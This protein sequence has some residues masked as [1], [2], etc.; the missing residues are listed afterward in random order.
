MGK[1][2]LEIIGPLYIIVFSWLLY[3]IDLLHSSRLPIAGQL[4]LQVNAVLLTGKLNLLIKGSLNQNIINYSFICVLCLREE[5]FASPLRWVP[6]T[7]YL[8]YILNASRKKIKNEDDAFPSKA[9]DFKL[10]AER[11]VYIYIFSPDET[12]TS[13][14]T[15]LSPMM[16]S[17]NMMDKIRRSIL[18]VQPFQGKTQQRHKS[19]Q[20]QGL[21]H[22]CFH[23]VCAGRCG[24]QAEDVLPTPNKP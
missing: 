6:T 15:T 23:G 16:D 18:T 22:V 9:V 8:A 19:R 12:Y 14:S 5:A 3:I 20:K 10:Q 11:I 1:K 7:Y 2:P 17:I 21:A 24:V 4:G 13:K